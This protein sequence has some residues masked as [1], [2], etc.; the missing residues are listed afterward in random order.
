MNTVSNKLDPNNAPSVLIL[1]GGIS[2]RM[3][4]PKLL[5]LFN[6]SLNFIEQIVSEYLKITRTI[7]LVLNENVYKQNAAY[8]TSQFPD[9]TLVINS[10]PELGRTYSIQLG[11]GKVKSDKVFIQ[12]T[13]NPFVKR[14]LLQEMLKISPDNGFVSPCFKNKGGHPVLL[15]GS[16]INKIKNS[17]N[18]ISLKEILINEIRV[19]YHSND[20]TVLLNIDTPESYNKYFAGNSDVF[21]KHYHHV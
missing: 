9:L 12:N 2:S 1:A 5:K 3:K 21:Q 4:Y 16:A 13:D 6:G 7:I 15:C 10:S 14:E 18:N 11:L 20:E 8:F 17:K 19:S